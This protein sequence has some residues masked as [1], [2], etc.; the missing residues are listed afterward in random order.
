[1]TQKDHIFY[2]RRESLPEGEAVTYEEAENFLLEQLEERNGACKETLWQLA[3]VYSGMKRH[4]E[5]LNCVYKLLQLS[6]DPEENASCFLA[7]GQLMEQKGDF[8]SA[9]D[10][11]RGAFVLKPAN[12]RTWYFINNNLGFCLTILKRY[13]EAEDYLKAAVDINPDLSNAYK[14]LGLCYQGQGDYVKAAEQFIMAVKVNASDPRPVQH[15]EDLE[16]NHPNIFLE[17]PDISDL[18]KMC[19]K[20]VAAARDIQPD[21]ADHWKKLRKKQTATKT[22]N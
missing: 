3:R 11:Y 8:A 13:S 20:A 21:P 5:A 4:D 1:M 15:L 18:F 2:F 12:T 16:K 22:E 6:D 7:L 19:K 14:N 9:V 10:Y 17:N